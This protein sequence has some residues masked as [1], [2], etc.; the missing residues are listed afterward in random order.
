MIYIYRDMYIIDPCNYGY[1]NTH[2]HVKCNSPANTPMQVVHPMVG[3]QESG[4]RVERLLISTTNLSPREENQIDCK[5][6]CPQQDWICFA[7][8]WAQDSFFKCLYP[9][10]P[11]HCLVP[12][13]RGNGARKI[14]ELKGG[15]S[16]HVCCH[17]AYVA[18]LPHIKAH[19]ESFNPRDLNLEA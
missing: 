15:F 14:M 3:P 10:E 19:L 17:Q 5:V 12:T 16:S 2:T 1:C 13:I 7:R 9:Q 18:V 11:P 8:D 6:V 4:Y